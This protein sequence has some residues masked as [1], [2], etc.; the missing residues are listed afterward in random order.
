MQYVLTLGSERKALIERGEEL[1][2][3]VNASIDVDI[4]KEVKEVYGEQ[5]R[6]SDLAKLGIERRR[7]DKDVEMV[8]ASGRCMKG[9]K[10]DGASGAS[11][12]NR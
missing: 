1:S 9:G 4:K 5:C 12:Q 8:E 10:N 7:K 6:T 2:I 3:R 11:Q